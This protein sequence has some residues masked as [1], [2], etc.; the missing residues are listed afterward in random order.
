MAD[1]VTIPY[2]AMTSVLLTAKLGVANELTLQAA[3]DPDGLENVR[4]ARHIPFGL[5]K[6]LN[7]LDKDAAL[8]KAGGELYCDALIYLKRDEFKRLQGKS[9]DEV[10]DCYLPFV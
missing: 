9:V 1:C 5:D 7:A 10:R 4:E 6:S 8:R 3:E 2:Q